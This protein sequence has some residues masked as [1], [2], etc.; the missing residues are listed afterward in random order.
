LSARRSK[1]WLIWIG[2]CGLLAQGAIAAPLDLQDPTPRWIEVRFEVSTDDEPGR[3]DGTWS[4]PRPAF[5]ESDADP[6]ILRIRIPAD[7]IEAHLRS[8]GT[9]TIPGSFSDFLWI[10]D[11]STGHVL[12][13]Q[14]TGRVRERLSLGPIRTSATAGIRVE[15]T[16]RDAAGFR[17]AGGLFGLRTNAFCLPS[18]QRARC[19]AVA[20]KPFNPKT[21]YVNAV[22]SMVAVAPIAEIHVF[23][24]LGEARFS[25]K[26]SDGTETAVSGTSQ[27]DAVCSD[28][29][30]GPC[31]ADLGGES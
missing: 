4:G 17:P 10:L 24:P 16:T 8:I 21:G 12:A 26:A 2:S 9:D 3:L 7:E 29:F 22:G 23:S 27:A 5:L 6:S 18:P 25:E 11:S 15:M 30:D 13:A 14:L 28:G 19:V 31:G 20:P 1:D